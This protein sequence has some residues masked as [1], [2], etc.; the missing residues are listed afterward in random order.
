MT[1]TQLAAAEDLGARFIEMFQQPHADPR[2]F[3]D[4]LRTSAPI[5]KTPLGFWFVSS[6]DLSLE[7]INGDALW[8]TDPHYLTGGPPNADS[9]AMTLWNR[10][11]LYNDGQ[12]HSRLRRLVQPVFTATAIRRLQEQIRSVVLSNLDL[13]GDATE[14]EFITAYAERLPTVIVM[15]LLG[16]PPEEIELFASTGDV[17][18]KLWEPTVTTA[19]VEECDRVWR[20]AADIVLAAIA[21]RRK[22]PQD[23]LLSRLIAATEDQD[24]L[25]DEE[26]VAMVLHLAVAGQE[27]TAHL[28]T[29]GLYHFLQ[30]PDLLASIR[31]DPDQL[32]AVVEEMLRYE[33]SARCEVMRYATRDTVLGGLAIAKGDSLL[34]GIQAANHD[35][36]VFSSPGEFTVGR[37]PNQHIGLGRGA[38]YC[39]GAVLAK[40]EVGIAWREILERYPDLA[41]IGE[42]AQWSQSL[43]LR[44]LEALPLRLQ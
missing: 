27:T 32:P 44:R 42:E 9:F 2:P 33:S 20:K 8:S 12:T 26:L 23:D 38:H 28:L 10:N 35:P 21:E 14:I 22:A 3:Y 43:A 4:E 41:L 19:Q 30:K 17:I 24:R 18:S 15:D 29:N 16:L 34:V 25:S 36:A 1:M 6:Y 31:R 5:F 40:L 13:L 37:T 11:M 39:L 7:V